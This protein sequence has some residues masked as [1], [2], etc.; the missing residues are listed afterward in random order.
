MGCVHARGRRQAALLVCVAAH[1][2]APALASP[3]VLLLHELGLRGADFERL[4]E[5]RVEIF[6]MGIVTMRR[7]LRFLQ[8]AI[9]L[10][11]ALRGWQAA[12]RWRRRACSVHAVHAR[13]RRPPP[14]SSDLHHCIERVQTASL[15]PA[16][17]LLPAATPTWQRWWLSSRAF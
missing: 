3:Q 13:T 11:C 8:D 2:P 12:P 10:T 9:G 6:Q 15:P 17:C 7:K 4:A 14:L 1:A 5:T 16:S